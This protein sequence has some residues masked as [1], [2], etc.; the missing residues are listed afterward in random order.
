MSLIVDSIWWSIIDLVLKHFVFSDSF[1]TQVRLRELTRGS[2]TTKL[3]GTGKS[4]SMVMSGLTMIWETDG[5]PSH[6]GFEFVHVDTEI[7]FLGVAVLVQALIDES[8]RKHIR[9]TIGERFTRFRV[10]NLGSVQLVEHK[11]IRSY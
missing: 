3:V 10:G 8:S 5:Y 11:M 9:L 4:Q 6:L 7:H 1:D 2:E